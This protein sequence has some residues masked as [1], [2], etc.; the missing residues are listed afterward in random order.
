[1]LAALSTTDLVALFDSTMS[2]DPIQDQL[3]YERTLALHFRA[4]EALAKKALKEAPMRLGRF[5]FS[6]CSLFYY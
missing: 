6:A 1:M 2:T 4:R 3:L 5:L